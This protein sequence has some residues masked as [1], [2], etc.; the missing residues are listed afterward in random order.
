MQEAKVTHYVVIVV[1]NSVI[2]VSNEL[3]V[4]VLHRFT[5]PIEWSKSLGS[6]QSISTISMWTNMRAI[7]WRAIVSISADA[8]RPSEGPR[9]QLQLSQQTLCDY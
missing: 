2:V 9:F 1:S 5:A 4:G 6:I 7:N 8:S 3:L